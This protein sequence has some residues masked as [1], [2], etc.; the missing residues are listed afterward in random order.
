M[1]YDYFFIFDADNVLDKN[2]LKNMQKAIVAGYEVAVGCRKMFNEKNIVAMCSFSS[3]T[4]LNMLSNNLRNKYSVNSIISGSGI[5]IKSS[6]LDKLG[7]FP[8]H[9]LTEDVEL[10]FYTIINNLPTTFIDNAIIYDEQPHTLKQLTAQK[11]R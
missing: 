3:F 5:F 2:F 1:S 8:F 11:T 7:E 10:T 4:I 9:G 6:I